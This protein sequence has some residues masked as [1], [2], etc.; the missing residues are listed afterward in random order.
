M[1]HFG[2]ESPKPLM[3]KGTASWLGVFRQVYLLRKTRLNNCTKKRLTYRTAKGHFTGKQSELEG[4][5]G[6]TKCFGRCVAL[7]SLK[8]DA[9]HVYNALI[10]QGL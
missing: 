6:Y 5:A 7:C 2:G 8:L 9:E 1:G 3:L 4:S 10:E